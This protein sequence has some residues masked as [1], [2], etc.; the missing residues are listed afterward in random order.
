MPVVVFLVVLACLLGAAVGG[1]YSARLLP[2]HHLSA[3]TKDVIY[4]F[5]NLIALL[6]AVVLG[7][8]I[9]AAKTSY[10]TKDMEWKHASANIVLLDRALAH[11]GPEAAAARDLLKAAVS[12]K[13]AQL[14]SKPA[15]QLSSGSRP[16]VAGIEEVQDAV[17]NLSPTTDAQRLSRSRALDI[18]GDIAK[19][20]WFLIENVDSTVPLAFLA[21]LV[22]WLAFIFFSYGLFAERNATVISVLV[23]CA[24]SLAGSVYLIFEMDNYMQGPISISTAP[25]KRAI[26][27]LGQ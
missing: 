10:D 14:E 19:A 26:E 16:L 4:A 2:Q 13:L 7:L 17:R 15:G 24:L 23:L 1:L 9:F 21:V 20:R 27:N 12:R 22:F 18:G 25:L 8:L 6:A 5:M 11:Y 3:A